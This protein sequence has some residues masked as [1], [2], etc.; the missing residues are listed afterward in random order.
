M[1]D[2]IIAFLRIGD[3][4]N[5]KK[6]L[7]RNGYD[8]NA[9]CDTG[10]QLISIANELDGGIVICGYQFSDMLYSEVYNYLP[11]SFTMIVIASPKKLEYLVEEDIWR[12]EMPIHVN[13][14]I[15]AVS[16]AAAEHGRKRKK[17]KA[18][19]K[20]RSAREQKLI[21]DAKQLLMDTKKI[22]ENEAH[23]YLQKLSMD[24]GNSIEESAGMILDIHK[25]SVEQ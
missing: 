10:S 13:E 4:R 15:A 24:S 23:R 17:E 5:L 7:E 14:L 11:K 2:I 8:V 20:F 22:T 9:V 18:K 16:D 19:P 12:I 25:N 1:P 21:D 6:L 3:A